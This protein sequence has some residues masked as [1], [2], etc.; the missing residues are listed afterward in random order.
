MKITP[1]RKGAVKGFRNNYLALLIPLF[2]SFN[3][4]AQWI[5]PNNSYGTISNGQNIQ[6][7]L[8]FPTGCGAPSL[9]NS[10]DSAQ[11]K[12]AIYGDSCNNKVYF[13]NPKTVEWSVISGG[14]SCPLSISVTRDNL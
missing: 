3:A 10:A 11:L 7:I 5:K 4:H 12:Y 6:R 1:L 13:Y 2:L 14:G 8:L 9:P